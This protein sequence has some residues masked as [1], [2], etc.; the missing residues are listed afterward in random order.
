MLRVYLKR[1]LH[2]ELCHQRFFMSKWA[3]L[4]LFLFTFCPFLNTMTNIAQNLYM[5]GRSIDGVLG[6]Q[7]Q[8]HNMVGVNESTEL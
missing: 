5:I 2:T 6:I 8:D 4:G 1:C 7:T 3:K